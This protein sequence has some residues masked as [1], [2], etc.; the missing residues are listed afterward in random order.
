[1]TWQL[2]Y[3]RHQQ[4]WYLLF[5][6]YVY[7]NLPKCMKCMDKEQDLQ[8]LNLSLPH[9]D[10]GVPPTWNPHI[11]VLQCWRCLT[12]SASSWPV[13][14]FYGYWGWLV[15]GGNGSPAW[16]VLWGSLGHLRSSWKKNALTV[17]NSLGQKSIKNQYAEMTHLQN[18]NGQLSVFMG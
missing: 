9:N 8:V 5:I 16:P 2:K 1:M 3:P 6:Y 7:R 10:A 14:A 17:L 11:D 18:I 13:V 15:A 12:S 4:T